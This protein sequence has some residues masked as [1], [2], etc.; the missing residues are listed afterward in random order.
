MFEFFIQPVFLA[1]CMTFSFRILHIFARVQLLL[2][3]VDKKHL[4]N[5]PFFSSTCFL[6]SAA[7]TGRRGRTLC[8][9][10]STVTQTQIRLDT[11]TCSACSSTNCCDK[12]D[13]NKERKYNI[14]NTT[15]LYCILNKFSKLT[16]NNIHRNVHPSQP[17][18]ALAQSK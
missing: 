15:E 18:I 16:A 2:L 12:L 1:A 4:K 17:R 13:N 6:T 5:S 7:T 8:G 10:G 14:H 11:T 9:D 3:H